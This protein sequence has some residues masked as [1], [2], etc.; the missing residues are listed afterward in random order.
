MAR[1]K[2]SLPEH[3]LFSTQI[4][5]RITDINF[6]GHVGNDAILGILHE[7]RTQY[8]QHYNYQEL[9]MEGVGLIMSDV[10]IEFRKELF[11]GDMLIAEV[12]ASDFSK[13]AFDILYK[14]SL[15][16][17]GKRMTVVLAK[18]GMV[19]FDYTHKKIVAVPESARSRL[20]AQSG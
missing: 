9:N 20:S 7:A 16:K 8:L 14:L 18:T 13:V 1:I 12:T 5:I 11:Y 19:C 10:A 4:C 6:G 3:F 15:E 17:E 2:L